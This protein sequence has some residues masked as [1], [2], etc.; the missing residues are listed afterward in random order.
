[1]FEF[2][3]QDYLE[4]SLEEL[5]HTVKP[6]NDHPVVALVGGHN[7]GKSSW[8]NTLAGR[9]VART[10]V[11]PCTERIENYLFSVNRETGCW[12]F[13]DGPLMPE[14]VS[15]NQVTDS[16]AVFVEVVDT[17]GLGSRERGHTWNLESIDR[18]HV[19]ITVH[20]AIRG[21]RADEKR[22][23]EEL[24]RDFPCRVYMLF[25][26]ADEVEDPDAA[27]A[28]LR[29]TVQSGLSG[30]SRLCG[31]TAA[32]LFGP[33]REP[34]SFGD[35]LV[36]DLMREVLHRRAANNA[37]VALYRLDQLQAAWS[38]TW[39]AAR[40][41][42]ADTLDERRAKLTRLSQARATCESLVE[43]AVESTVD[44]LRRWTIDTLDHAVQEAKA[45]SSEAAANVPDEAEASDNVIPTSSEASREKMAKAL[46]ER[47]GKALLRKGQEFIEQ[48]MDDEAILDTAKIR[49]HW[50]ME[51]TGKLLESR[52]A[53][54]FEKLYGAVASKA[55]AYELKVPSEGAA[56]RLWGTEVSSKWLQILDEELVAA[57]INSNTPREGLVALAEATTDRFATSWRSEAFGS[58]FTKSFDHV[59]EEDQG[60][61]SGLVA[62]LARHD[63]EYADALDGLKFIRSD[64]ERHAGSAL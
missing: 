6:A 2:D 9:E 51:T 63:R 64:I 15:K 56:P 45:A 13:T 31:F 20:T 43:D 7:T 41:S 27:L 40:K 3:H 49:E 19:V 62:D 54:H 21:V 1:M 8:I 24:L 52:L 11:L 42:I 55:S 34:K 26:R 33:E 47:A 4:L 38:E 61:E 59:I 53:A 32:G 28:E 29:K 37:A 23:L 22:P 36:D 39:Q 35:P 18:A 44:V 58:D 60:L 50:D 57:S 16:N 14:D 12:D 30:S 17:P 46:L 5:W 10:D 25:T 48:G